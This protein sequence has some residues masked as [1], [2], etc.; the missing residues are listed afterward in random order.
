MEKSYNDKKKKE[1]KA[2]LNQLKDLQYII[3]ETLYAIESENSENVGC[4]LLE[5]IELAEKDL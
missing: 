4:C 1:L 3:V 5:A 2:L